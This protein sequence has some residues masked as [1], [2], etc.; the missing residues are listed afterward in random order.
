MKRSHAAGKASGA[1]VP[2]WKYRITQASSPRKKPTS[3][4]R[5]IVR[6]GRIMVRK[7]ITAQIVPMTKIPVELA[8]QSAKL[9]SDGFEKMMPMEQGEEGGGGARRVATHDTQQW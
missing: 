4:M 1:A 9:T 3:R 7:V 8:D 2:S 5:T 6:V